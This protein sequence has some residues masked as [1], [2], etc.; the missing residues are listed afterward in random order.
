VS[1]RAGRA[2]T[3]ALIL[4]SGV[5]LI[6]VVRALALAGIRSQ[7]VPVPGEPAARSRH[8]TV[9]AS[10]DWADPGVGGEEE[11]VAALVAYGR[12]QERPLPLLFTSDEALLLVSGFRDAL[13]AAFRFVL[14]PHELVLDLADKGRFRELAER[15]DLPVPPTVVLAPEPGSA[16]PAVTELGL[17]LVIKPQ[18]RDRGWHDGLGLRGKAVHVR[19]EAELAAVWPAVSSLRQTILVQRAIAGREDRIESYHVYVDERGQVA[20]EFTGRKIRTLPLQYG[21]TTALEIT[22]IPDVR[23]CGRD[24]VGRLGLVGVAKFDFKRDDDGRLYLLEV[25]PR[26]HLWH[27]PA[28]RA[29][30]NLPALM[31]ADL[32][33]GPRPVTADRAA[34]VTWCHPLDVVAAR[35]DGMGLV[36]WARWASRCEA[37]AFWSW[38]DPLPLVA[39]V[40]RRLRR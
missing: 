24:L 35:Q 33:G 11:F 14:P 38:E 19:T 8:A 10:R 40:A 22:D 39:A 21:H 5:N 31:H 27:H 1:A 28:A 2:A 25:N 13:G 3:D 23:E 29:G 17:P 32:I 7:V 26:C 9:V 34:H 6:E 16:P 12:R 30:V 18:R 4:G 37:K 20:G 15:L 36:A